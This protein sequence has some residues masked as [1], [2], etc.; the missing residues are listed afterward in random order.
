MENRKYKK[1]KQ[2][3]VFGKHLKQMLRCVGKAIGS[4]LGSICWFIKTLIAFITISFICGCLIAG[5]LYIKIKPDLD[6]CMEIAYDKLVGMKDSDF[7]KPMDTYIYDKD[8]NTIGIINAGHFEYVGIEDISLNIQNAYISQE[9][10]RFKEHCGVDLIST[11][12]AGLALVKNKGAITQGGSTITQQVI[13]NT[14]LTQEQSFKRKLIEFMLAPRLEAKYSKSKIMEFYCNTNYYGNGC[15]GVQAAS[16]Y[17]FGK[18][19]KNLSIAE[20]ALLAGLSNSPSAYDPVDHP[21]KA[22]EKRD[23]VIRNLQKNGFITE[24]QEASALN[25][26]MVIEQ[27]QFASSIENYQS[28]Y[29]VHCAA[30]KLMEEENFG[31]QYTFE[32]KEDYDSYIQKYSDVYN[33]KVDEIRSGGYKIYTALDSNIQSIAQEKLD[34]ALSKFTE[35]Q[36]NGKYAL[37]GSAVVADNSSGYIVAVIGGRGTDDQFNR[38]Y[39]S[40]RQPGSVIKPLIDYTPAFDTGLY[41][42]SY[43]VNDHLFDGGPKN[44]GGSYRGNITIREAVNRSLNTVAW[45][46]LQAIGIDN[47]LQYLGDMRFSKITYVDND[48]P[49]LSIGGFTNGLRIVDITKGYQ[50]LANDGLYNNNTCILDIKDES[51]LSLVTKRTEDKQIYEPDSAYMM[52][53]ILK[54]TLTESYGTGHGLAL[55]NMP[56]AGKTGTT[57]DNKDTWFA[58]YTKYY[59][60]SV[61]VGYDTPREMPGIYGATYAGKIWQSIMNEIHTGL[62]PMDWE[63]PDTVYRKTYDPGTG[64]PVE[65]DTGV[66]D[67]YSVTLEEKAT[68]LQEKLL[69]EKFYDEIRNKVETY[70]KTTIATVEDT[71]QIDKNFND[72]N[73]MISNIYDSKERTELYDRIYTKYQ[74]LVEIKDSMKDEIELYES[75]KTQKEKEDAIKA[76]KEA[77]ESRKKLIQTTREND[78]VDALKAITSLKYQTSNIDELIKTAEDKL[79]RIKEYPSYNDYNLQLQAAISNL[80]GLPTYQDYMKSEEEKRKAEEES[81]RAEESEKADL[82]SQLNQ[83][84]ESVENPGPGN[85]PNESELIGPGMEPNRSTPMYNEEGGPY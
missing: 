70:E 2:E 49:A 22:K 53:D 47:G 75:Q 28:S 6:S 27:K 72:M 51:G 68:H 52:T 46:I 38:T 16:Q 48:V 84:I 41:Y 76:E 60:T 20:S 9:D 17:Y 63:E 62:E 36:E 10:K 23:S 42:P 80:G 44:S 12:R 57:N 8:G 81:K 19:A 32:N 66:T 67:L 21:E 33:E 30:I 1:P 11:A 26:P 77:E 15:Y 40:A 56:A 18:N 31:F 83:M 61:W 65:Y 82:E 71:Y 78:F 45:Q 55:D 4:I 69:E 13:K 58:G 39:L 85:G 29:A 37:Q 59:T 35:T 14:Y 74:E 24:E 64:Q 50:T 54:G 79:T 7:Y 34:T 25:E 43:I 73:N 3:I 5:V